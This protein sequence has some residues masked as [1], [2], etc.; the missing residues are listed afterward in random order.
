MKK[1][2][3]QLDVDP[4]PCSFD[5]I[6]AVDAGADVLL[7]HGNVSPENVVSLVHGAMFT[8][9]DP[10]LPPRE[11]FWVAKT[12]LRL[13]KLLLIFQKLFGMLRVG[14]FIDPAGQTQR[15][16]CHCSKAA[17]VFQTIE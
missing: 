13:K 8:H 6:V 3:L 16:C 2:L 15:R 1:I 7:R 5:A 14:V 9:E 4:Q 10:T 11:F 12:F 17:Y